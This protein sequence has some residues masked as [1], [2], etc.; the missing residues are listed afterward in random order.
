VIVFTVTR[1]GITTGT[2][3]VNLTWTGTAALTTDYT[4]AVSGTGVTLS[5]NRLTLTFAAGATTATLTITPV[6]D[7][8]IEGPEALTMTI[9]A[10]TGYTVGSPSTATGTITDND[11]AP[12]VS[13]ATTDGTGSET[14]GDPIV[15]TVTRAGSTT[16]TTNVVLTWTGSATL[17]TDYTVAATGT[18]VT[19]SAN[20]LTLTFAAGATTAT[21]TITPVN[22]TAVEGPESLTMT[23]GSGTGY[24]VGSPSGASGTIIDNDVTIS[25]AVTDGA[26]SETPGDPIVFTVN[27]A[28]TTGTT[29][30]NLT[31]TGA[32]TLTADYTVVAS[33]T[34]VTLSADSLTLTFDPGAATSTLTL[35]P[36][37]D[38]AVEGPES[39][40]MTIAAGS[41]YT[42]GSPSSAA[43]TI[44]DN[45]V[46][47]TVSVATTDGSGSE[48]PGDPITF[49]LTRSGNT[50]G[51]TAANLTWSGTATLTTDYTVAVSAGATLSANNL[52]LT[53]AAGTA[54][55]TVTITP[56][57]DAV[58]EPSETVTM[59]IGSGT[60]YTVG[61]PSS[62]SGTIADNDTASLAIGDNSGL[63]GDKNTS[64]IVLTVTMSAP[65]ATT[66]TV[67]FATAAAGTGLGFA[68]AG[69]D[70]I[71]QSG[72]LTFS[73]GQTTATISI[74]INGDRTRGEGNETFFVNL[75][76]PN[77][78]TIADGQAI[79]QITDDD[80]AV[81]AGATGTN[82]TP[83][84]LDA[85]TAR[86]VLALAAATWGTAAGDIDLSIITIEIAD[87]PFD[88]LAQTSPDG[89]TIVIDV[90]A[91]G[92]GWQTDPASPVGPASIDLLSVLAHELGHVLGLEH[93]TSELMGEVIAP[94][95]RELPSLELDPQPPVVP[96]ATRDFPTMRPV[97]PITSVVP[98]ADLVVTR[99]LMAAPRHV[100]ATAVAVDALV[101]RSVVERAADVV[102]AATPIGSGDASP[103]SPATLWALLIGLGLALSARRRWR[104]LLASRQ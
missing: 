65:S 32:A 62:A 46:A 10:G 89:T 48:T 91:A 86:F 41:G 30:V 42:A 85:S 60:G 100:S 40:T 9:A 18:G 55:V 52:T 26:G 27:R 20:G 95:R 59:T 43:G 33:G 28:G 93:G 49:T 23:I 70:Y 15:F 102:S 69:T 98:H 1:S 79:V 92:W 84:T 45:D 4:V 96:A 99:S 24:T 16:G 14:P 88:L 76:G 66:V 11:A 44:A 80:G 35:T 3:T 74:V 13:V 58:V 64:T 82:P 63:E 72:T 12:T 104:Q 73:P 53:F 50:A 51:T 25:A 6:D 54:T 8:A 56:V 77:G 2:T 21:L 97:D 81:R 94:G 67:A 7:T 101:A 68:T 17:T 57:D 103:M 47:P 19:L 29:V 71:A 90:D 75:S 38:S 37:D 39:V 78:A 36:V 61:S 83:S 31:W 87:L 34:G 5:T 22:D